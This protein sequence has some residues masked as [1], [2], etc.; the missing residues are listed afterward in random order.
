MSMKAAGAVGVLRHARREAR[1]TE[2]RR[3]L[4]AGDAR[5]RDVAEA[6]RRRTRR[7]TPRS[8]AGP[9]AAWPRDAEELRAVVVP[10]PRV[11]VEEHRARRVGRVGDV[12]RPPVSFQTSQ[13]S[14]VP[15]ASS[16][17]L[18]PPR[19]PGDVVENPGD[20]AAGEVGVDHQARRSRMKSSWPVAPSAD[21]RVGGAAVLPDDRVV[22]GLARSRGPRRRS[23]RA[24]W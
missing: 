19:A 2:E 14:T 16:P 15:K 22:D 1:L 11:D 18:R 9:P 5:D 23:S 6:E 12:R 20:L 21:R 13:V 17:R 10:L 7:R 3:L 8:T 4:I 24:D